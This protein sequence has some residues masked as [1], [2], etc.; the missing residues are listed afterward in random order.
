MSNPKYS[1][2]GSIEYRLIEEL[3]ELIQAVC[4]A[5]RFGLSNYHP[6]EGTTNRD[7]IY[8]EIEDVEK[9]IAEYKVKL[10]NQL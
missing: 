10:K 5:R 7:R 1:K 9:V 8:M 6:T 4:K 3:S 2:I